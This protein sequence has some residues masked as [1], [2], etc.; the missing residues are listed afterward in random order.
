[1]TVLEIAAFSDG[2][3]GGNPAGVW[4]GETLPSAE[5]MQSIAAAIGHSE[6]VFAVPEGT[7]WRVR[8]FSPTME[9]PFCGHATI[10]LGA[11][12]AMANGNGIF[13]LAL[14][15]ADI[16]VEGRESAGTL[17]AALMS[18][19]TSHMPFDASRLNEYLNLF[20]Y[21]AADLDSTLLP[22]RIHA[23]ADHLLIP[24]ASR[25]ALSRLDYNLDLGATLMAEDKLITVMF[26]VADHGDVAS[27][28]MFWCRNAFA[29]GGVKE[30]P[31]TGAAAAAFCGYLRDSQLSAV[32]EFELRQ[33]DDMG[34]PSRL[35]VECTS[36]PGS[37]VRVAGAARVMQ[38][39]ERAR[40]QAEVEV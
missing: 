38:R 18:P 22:A 7:G 19:P 21:K 39:D 17:T 12:L 3:T 40:E 11:A 4:L 5:K 31:A 14:N 24:L 33:G 6:S 37:G 13:P 27:P 36:V 25:A 16:S 2:D 10:A 9:V 35:R 32:R 30:D 28:G 8:Y 15:D 26:C 34:I 1:M 20:G 23:G 29:V